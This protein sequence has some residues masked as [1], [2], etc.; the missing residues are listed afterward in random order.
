MVTAW[1][2]P[3][4]SMP[5]ARHGCQISAPAARA[6][7]AKPVQKVTAKCPAETTLRRHACFGADIAAEK[8]D[9]P[10][11]RPGLAAPHIADAE[12]VEQDKV[13]RGDELAAHLA[14]GN[15]VRSMIATVRPGRASVI[16]AA[17]PAGPAPMTI[18]SKIIALARGREDMAEQAAAPL[19]DRLSLAGRP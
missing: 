13:G 18:A 17:E 14:A 2:S 15:S 4:R 1:S 8:P 16:A 9:A 6:A 19:L 5:I 12:L 3:S 11:F 10:D 7:R